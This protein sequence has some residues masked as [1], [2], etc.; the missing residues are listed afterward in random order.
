MARKRKSRVGAVPFRGGFVRVRSAV[1]PAHLYDVPVR[2]FERHPERYVLV[3][4][5]PVEVARPAVMVAGAIAP[6]V[7]V[8]APGVGEN[9]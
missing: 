3:D 7:D 1:G 2:V 6:E 4:P 5:V 9:S 8:D